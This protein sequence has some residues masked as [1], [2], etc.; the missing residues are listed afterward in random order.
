VSCKLLQFS[1]QGNS[2]A[3]RIRAIEESWLGSRVCPPDGFVQ[4]WLEHDENSPNCKTNWGAISGLA[5]SAVISAG[6]WTGVAILVQR[7]WQ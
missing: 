6:F 5:L 1:P 3:M 2:G 4:V 7:I